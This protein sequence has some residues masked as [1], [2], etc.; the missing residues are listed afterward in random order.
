[1]KALQSELAKRILQAAFYDAALRKALRDFT[2]F[3]FEGKRYIMQ[4]VPKAD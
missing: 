2:P 3:T 4:R 1:M